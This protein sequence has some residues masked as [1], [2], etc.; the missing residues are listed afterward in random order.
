MNFEPINIKVS[1]LKSYV[2]IALA[3]DSPFFI[4]EANL[5]RKEYGITNPLRQKDWREWI[6]INIIQKKGEKAVAGLFSKITE[7]RA[8]MI[9]T[10]NYQ[11]VFEKAVFGCDIEDGDYETTLLINFQK[12]P[13][14]L[15]YKLP[16][17][18]MY[19]ILLTPQTRKMDLEK[20]YDKYLLIMSQ[21]RE[22][23]K[24]KILFDK[25]KDYQGQIKRD[26]KWYWEKVDG[27]NEL[28]IAEDCE[29]RGSMNPKDYEGT[30]RKAI[31]AYTKLLQPSL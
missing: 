12:L 2:D 30:V 3:I 23:E 25:S 27:K 10:P 6:D 28:Q 7:I 15:D 19:A 8:R 14:Y 26:R 17:S 9:L 20:L 16:I 21:F 22:G 13:E 24:T 1:D 4:T 5:I 29:E 18:E 11:V 31:A